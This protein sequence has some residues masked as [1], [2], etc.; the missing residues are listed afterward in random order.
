MWVVCG[1]VFWWLFGGSKG[2][3]TIDI[4]ITAGAVN[5]M[6]GEDKFTANPRIFD[7]R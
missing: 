3:V 7:V 2:G 1:C 5:R 4:H 6:N